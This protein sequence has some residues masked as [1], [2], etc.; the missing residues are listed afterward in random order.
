MP[1]VIY[2]VATR[3]LGAGRRSR[4]D[5]PAWARVRTQAG[6]WIELHAS[7]TTGPAGSQ[8]AVILQRAG[9]RALR[10][11]VVEAYGLT[12]RERELLPCLLRGESTKEIAAALAISPYTVQ[13]HLKSLFEKFGV[14]SR[15]EM[16]GRIF[17]QQG[18]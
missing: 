11:L 7:L 10:P 16:V 5:P 3:A 2:A 6:P 13:E 18:R 15:L 14:K 12:D 8:V 4:D 9:A 1:C 17:L